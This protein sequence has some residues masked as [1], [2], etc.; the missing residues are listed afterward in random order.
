MQISDKGHTSHILG[1]MPKALHPL[2]LD[3]VSFS[4]HEIIKSTEV[5]QYAYIKQCNYRNC[6]LVPNRQEKIKESQNTKWS[7]EKVEEAKKA[8]GTRNKKAL[9]LLEDAIVLEPK[10]IQAYLLRAKTHFEANK[11]KEAKE[12]YLEVLKINPQNE[13]AVKMLDRIKNKAQEFS[14]EIKDKRLFNSSYQHKLVY[15]PEFN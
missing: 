9:K 8:L 10:N 15:S 11:L 12:D 3:S 1:I 6:E 4:L 14:Y 5:D 13:T 7:N 2:I